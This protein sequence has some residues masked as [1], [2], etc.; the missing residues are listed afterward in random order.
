MFVI[1]KFQF[2]VAGNTMYIPG[3]SFTLTLERIPLYYLLNIIIPT[4]TLACLSALS[5]AVPVD[6]GEKLSLGI[7]ILLAFSVFMLILQDNTPQAESSLLGKQ[8][9]TH[10]GRRDGKWIG[11]H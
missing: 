9:G 2:T 5:F 7:S 10:L 6:S 8:M 4:A 11:I 3:V 1:V